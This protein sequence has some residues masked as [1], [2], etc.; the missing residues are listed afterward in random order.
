LK[1]KIIIRVEIDPILTGVVPKLLTEIEQSFP[2]KKVK[3]FKDKALVYDQLFYD[4]S[5]FV[6]RYS[7]QNDS[8]E[9]SVSYSNHC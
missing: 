2:I 7:R 9:V 3:E 8:I 6:H 1:Y 5:I 4:A